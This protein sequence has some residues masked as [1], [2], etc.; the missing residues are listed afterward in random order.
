MRR[1]K[2]ALVQVYKEI[3]ASLRAELQKASNPMSRTKL[4]LVQVYRE[5][6]T[7]VQKA[8]AQGEGAS[9]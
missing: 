6:R 3:W 8:Y 2:L 5:L 1:T 4:T 7:E 9:G